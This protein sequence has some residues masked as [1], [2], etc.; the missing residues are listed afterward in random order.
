MEI[1]VEQRLKKRR[2]RDLPTWGFNPYIVID[3][4]LKLAFSY[5]VAPVVDQPSGP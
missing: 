3:C 4:I 5:L 2:P 1:S